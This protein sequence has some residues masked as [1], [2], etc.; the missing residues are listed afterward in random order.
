VGQSFSQ[1][2]GFSFSIL[3]PQTIHLPS[4]IISQRGDGPIRDRSTKSLRKNT[5]KKKYKKIS[6]LFHSFQDSALLGL[7]DSSTFL[8]RVF[9]GKFCPII[10]AGFKFYSEGYRKLDFLWLPAIKLLVDEHKVWTRH[11]QNSSCS[12]LHIKSQ[13]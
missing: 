2:F 7:I 5:T 1:D 6:S 9:Y 8:S 10:L 3:V 4:S 12:L 11:K 13:L